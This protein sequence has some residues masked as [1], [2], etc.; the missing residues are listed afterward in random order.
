[1]RREAVAIWAIARKDIGVWMRQPTAIAATVLPAI[2]LVGVLYIGA[3]A[4]G[5]NPVALVV[6]DDGPHA[7]QLAAML[8]RS[9]AFVVT[10]A[11]A[12]EAAR[13][14]QTLRVAAVITIPPEFDAA[15]TAHQP[16]PVDIR[17]NNL[18]LDFT[19]D[20]RRSLPAAITSFYASQPDDPIDIHVQETDL[21]LQDIELLQFELIPD[22]VLLLTIAGAINA[23]LATAREWEDQTIKELLLAPISR[24]SL[25]L[26]K[27]LAGWLTTLLVAAII[28]SIGAGTGY[29]RP[30]AAGWLPTLVT[31]ALLALASAGLGVAIGAAARR[32]QRVASLTIP[33]AFYLFFLSGGISVVA[34]LPDWVQTIAQ[35]IPTYY[36]MHALQMVVFYD[37]T[38]DLGRDLLVLM[39]TAAAM[40][41]LGVASLRRRLAA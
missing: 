12:D 26:G 33:L 37:S 13:D 41:A 31:V 22:L 19:N 36:G 28:M 21:R 15:F 5:R 2:V 3:A 7:Q 1:M 24:G 8:E 29:L 17:I 4:V 11:T 38:E 20:L 9:D 40:L 30:S 23:G 32:V 25:I 34:F 6:Q 16:D 39:V 14:L 35:F 27:L 10:P 18:N